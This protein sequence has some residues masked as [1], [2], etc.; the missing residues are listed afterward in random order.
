MSET[1]FDVRNETG[2]LAVIGFQALLDLLIATFSIH[3]R[4]ILLHI[5]N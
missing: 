4:M 5:N 1:K 3:S 2:A